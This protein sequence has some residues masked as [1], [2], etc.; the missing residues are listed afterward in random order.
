M[1]S[2]AFAPV[3]LLMLGAFLFSTLSLSADRPNI[4]VILSDDMGYSDIGAYG[5]E[6]RTPELDR[7]AREGRQFTQFYNS[8]RCCPSRASLLTGLYPHQAGVGHLIYPTIHPGYGDRLVPDS[9]TMAEVLREAGYGTYMAGKWHLAPRRYDPTT[10][11]E[12]WPIRRG[13]ERFYGTIAG[14]GSFWDPSTLCRQETLITPENDTAY[15]PE[16]FYYTDAITDN[17]LMFL[18]D[19]EAGAQQRPFFLYLSYTAAHWPL[20]VPEEE[21]RAYAGEYDAGYAVVHAR[22]VERLRQLGLIPEVSTIDDPIGDWNGVG[23]KAVEAALMEAYAAM[24]T[25][26]DKG[27][28]QIMAFLEQTGQADNTLVFYLQDNGACSEDWFG[29]ETTRTTPYEPMG[30]DELQRSYRPLQT[31][32]GRPVRMGPEV[33]PGPDDT[34][35][36]YKENWAN[37]SNAPFRKYKHY[38]HEGGISS[39]LIVHWPARL[40]EGNGD[41]LVREPAHLIDIMSTCLEAAS[42]RYPVQRRGIPLQSLEGTSLLNVMTGRSSGL[43]ERSLFWE[44]EGNRAVRRGQWKLVALDAESWELYDLDQDRG[45][46]RNLVS[47]YPRVAAELAAEWHAWATRS[48]VLPLGGWM[49]LDDGQVALDLKE[50]ETLPVEKSPLLKGHEVSF[51]LRVLEGPFEGVLLQQGSASD[52]YALSMENDCLRLTMRNDGEAS[53]MTLAGLPR[54]PFTIRGSIA[55]NGRARLSIDD[56]RVDGRLGKPFKTDPTSG[57]QVGSSE[58]G[59]RAASASTAFQGRLGFVTIRGSFPSDSHH[60]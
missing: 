4:I 31:R 26:M 7:L 3:F 19:H 14:S 8:A 9:I 47:T 60:E 16:T 33:M 59:D 53:S 39:P 15:Q 49:D 5:G 43:A 18:R 51:A 55:A 25:R 29:A 10:D 38:V 22:R 24:V 41:R 2:H 1:K 48:K 27:I 21:M 23:N 17:A 28:G 45:E 37:V 20:H 44:H 12:H 13:F 56:R 35:T 46:M 50:G 57:L 42:V 40:G 6:I 54:A 30:S 11:L 52:G 34:Y 58:W 32:D 36:A